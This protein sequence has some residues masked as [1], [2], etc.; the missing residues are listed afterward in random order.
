M[1]LLAAGIII[2]IVLLILIPVIVCCCFYK[3]T[4]DRDRVKNDILAE[5]SSFKNVETYKKAY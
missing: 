3:K 4:E 5:L 2:T 1:G